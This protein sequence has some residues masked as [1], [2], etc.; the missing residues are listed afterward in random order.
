MDILTK[1]VCG[2]HYTDKKGND[3][4]TLHL[5]F[6]ES[7]GVKYNN[8]MKIPVEGANCIVR[9]TPRQYEGSAF[10]GLS[11]VFVEGEDVGCIY[12]PDES[13]APPEF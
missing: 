11:V 5:P 12:G 7:F 2:K 3:C 4:F 6:G 8:S 13:E 1:A 9:V 10:F